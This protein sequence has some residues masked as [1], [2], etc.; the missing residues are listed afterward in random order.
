MILQLWAKEF[1]SYNLNS[2][3]SNAIKADLVFAGY[4]T[5]EH[6]EN[7]HYIYIEPLYNILNSLFHI[8]LNLKKDLLHN[9][10]FQNLLHEIYYICHNKQGN[11]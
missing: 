10:N 2:E 1:K 4:P 9:P 7:K 11:L 3:F 5:S 8:T 6:E